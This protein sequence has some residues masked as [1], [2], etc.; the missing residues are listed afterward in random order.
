MKWFIPKILLIAIFFISAKYE[1][2]KKINTCSDIMNTDNFGF[3]YIYCNNSLNKYSNSGELLSTYSNPSNG[4]I[5]SID[6]SD[7]YILL[8]F[9]E[10]LNRIVFL[11]NKLAP[12]GGPFDLDKLGLFNTSA[13]CKSKNFA[14]WIFD[15][16]ENR[17]V[18]YS[19]NPKGIIQE[20][21]LDPLSLKEELNFMLESGKYLYLNTGKQLIIFD[22]YG[23]YIKSIQSE[24]KKSFQVRNNNIIYF[25]DKSLFVKSVEK[26]E[27]D[28]IHIDFISNIKNAFIEADR[29]Y[30]Q[31]TDTVLIYKTN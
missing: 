12:I 21:S 20:F 11:D 14:V 2:I 17:I 25:Q 9:F 4:K 31:K 29:L 6:V 19:F 22:Q 13:V 27:A 23:S 15:S 16:F 10:D 3:L 5:S 28:T 30:V 1:L 8:L 18:N 24:V 7:P 26:D